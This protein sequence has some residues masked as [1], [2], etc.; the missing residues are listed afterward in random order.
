MNMRSALLS[1]TA[2]AVMAVNAHAGGISVKAPVIPADLSSWK[3]FESPTGDYCGKQGKQVDTRVYVRRTHVEN[4]AKTYFVFNINGKPVAYL[5]GLILLGLLDKTDHPGPDTYFKA[6][7]QQRSYILGDK[8][9]MS[10]D[11][12]E[13]DEDSKAFEHVLGVATDC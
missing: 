5:E 4:T 13:G 8:G 6:L 9:W 12:K 2:T 3:S 11:P 7:H 10:Y 1:V